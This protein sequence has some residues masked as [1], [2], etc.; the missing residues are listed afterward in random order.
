ENPRQT[1]APDLMTGA[2]AQGW[3]AMLRTLVQFE[4]WDAILDEKTLPVYGKARQEAWRHWARGIA[5]V[6]RGNAAAAREEA[7]LFEQSITDLRSK[8]QRPEP[9]ELQVARRELSGH[10]ELA[11]GNVSR[12]LKQLEAA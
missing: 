6:N 10:L 3:F 12:G 7:R 9:P 1:A 11:A 5:Y 2:K 8:T 4:K